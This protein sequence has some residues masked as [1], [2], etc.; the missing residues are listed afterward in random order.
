MKPPETIIAISDPGEIDK[1]QHNKGDR[2]NIWISNLFALI[3]PILMIVICTQVVFR[4][5][6]RSEIGPGNQAWLDDFQWWLYGAAVLI[7]IG[8]A[9]STNSHVRVDIFYDKYSEQKRQ[10]IDII[11]LTWFFL[12]F[13]VLCWDVTLS[14]AITSI[15]A[16]EGSDSPNG[17]HN[18]WVLKLFM[19]FSFILIGFATW[20]AYVRRLS[21]ATKPVIW[22]QLLYAFPATLFIINLIIYYSFWWVIYLIS[23]QGTTTRQVGRHEIFG[24]VNIFYWEI[25]YTIII[26][27]IVTVM[28]IGLARLLD[29]LKQDHTDTE[30]T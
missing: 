20:S 1:E 18:L 9:I 6:G 30:A 26:S 14:Y 12:P 7:G 17:L 5:L 16:D 28:I 19:N 24:D 8:Y 29:L 13:V 4:T 10:R 25:K 27:I 2:I 11:A 15:I 22:K 23:E 3:F 21:Q